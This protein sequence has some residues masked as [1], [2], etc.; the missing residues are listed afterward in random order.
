SRHQGYTL[1]ISHTGLAHARCRQRIPQV[2]DTAPPVSRL[3][4]QYHDGRPQP[5]GAAGEF[6]EL[7]GFSAPGERDN[8][9]T[10][11]DGPEAAVQTVDGVHEQGWR[12]GHRQQVGQSPRYVARSPHTNREHLARLAEDALGGGVDARVELGVERGRG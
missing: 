11:L 6:V 5:L 2:P 7:V 10:G 4:R 3:L 8:D 1:Y 12:A 9:I